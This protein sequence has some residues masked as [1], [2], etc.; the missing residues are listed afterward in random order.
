MRMSLLLM[1]R[2]AQASEQCPD[3]PA[4]E[5]AKSGSLIA[6]TTV[7]GAGAGGFG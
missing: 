3:C 5:A 6:G 1:M 2:N 7:N 4:Q